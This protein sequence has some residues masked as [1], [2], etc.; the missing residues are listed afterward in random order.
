MPGVVPFGLAADSFDAVSLV[1]FG[2]YPLAG[3]GGRAAAAHAMKPNI[4]QY[5]TSAARRNCAAVACSHF[6]GLNML[7]E[8]F[9]KFCRAER[10]NSVSKCFSI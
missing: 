9:T 2:P 4:I 8:Y 10:S 3:A 5:S 6:A 1:I 7:G